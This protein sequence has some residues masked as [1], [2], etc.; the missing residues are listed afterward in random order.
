MRV[1]KWIA[2]T[3]A[4]LLVVAG[5]GGAYFKSAAQARLDKTYEVKVDPVPIPFPLSDAEVEALRA[6]RRALLASGEGVVEGAAGE[7]RADPLQGVDLAAIALERAI[8]RG[9]H[10]LSSRA[11][12]ADC[13]GDDMG[14]KVIIENPVMGTWA[15]PNITR[16]G[17]TKDYKSEDWIRIIRH[18]VKPDG[19]ATSMPSRDFANFSDQEVSDIAAFIQNLP[20]VD[21][22][23]QEIE[24][25]PIFSMLLAQGEV[26]ISAEVIDHV[27]KRPL[28]PPNVAAVSLELGK[29]LAGTCVGCHGAGLS[30]GP[31]QG[32]D[33]A[34]LP[35]KNLT[36]DDS[37]LA[38]WTLSDFTK[39]MRD[40][41]RPDG[42]NIGPPMPIA[43]TKQFTDAEVESMYEYLKTAPKKPYGQF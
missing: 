29:H 35:A 41:V 23:D 24:F 40:G 25:G 11:A 38:G 9:K 28:Y 8:E 16:G 15:A 22:P 20:A 27:S 30:G 34:W 7:E 42:V 3:L 5:I 14:G 18:G 26:P 37:G 10:Y 1:L 2:G 39:A 32:G 31:I 19:R 43:Y 21:R 36:F 4:G 6:E 13:H 12:C 17:K 33:P